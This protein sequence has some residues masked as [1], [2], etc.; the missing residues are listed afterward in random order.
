MDLIDFTNCKSD[1]EYF[2]GDKMMLRIVKG[3][4]T[5]QKNVSKIFY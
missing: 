3:L 4:D 5:M 1:N 2:N